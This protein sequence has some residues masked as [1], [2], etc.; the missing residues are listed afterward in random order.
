MG[1]ERNDVCHKESL[2][3]KIS[4]EN[5]INLFDRTEL[6]AKIFWAQFAQ[7][8]KHIQSLSDYV[9]EAQLPLGLR[10]VYVDLILNHLEIF[11]DLLFVSYGLKL[12]TNPKSQE[13]VTKCNHDNLIALGFWAMDNSKELECISDISSKWI[14]H[15]LYEDKPS[16]PNLEELFKGRLVPVEQESSSSFLHNIDEK[17]KRTYIYA[18]Y[19][20]DKDEFEVVKKQIEDI[21][22]TMRSIVSL[23]FS[24]LTATVKLMYNFDTIVKDFRE[25]ERGQ[26]IIDRW[27]HDLCLPKEGLVSK[28]KEKDD[29]KPWVDKCCLLH[30]KKIAKKELFVDN[31]IPGSQHNTDLYK[32]NSWLS[33]FTI[34]AILQEYDKKHRVVLEFKPFFYNDE[35]EA[36]KFIDKIS[37]L[38]PMMITSL[39]KKMVD[40]DHYPPVLKSKKFCDLLIKHKLY[41]KS[42]QNWND[43]V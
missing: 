37:G 30:E 29:L 21:D 42:Y 20:G 9:D 34:T 39:I 28:L 36:R 26:I 10:K 43:Q 32:T 17:L 7:I 25:S 5:K 22:E 33:I 11:K 18:P 6:E 23:I 1:I 15:F 12:D 41:T 27:K 3:K 38:E 14:N 13:C 16:E 35:E 31:S 2:K 40:K 8:M 19:Q 24:V 4:N